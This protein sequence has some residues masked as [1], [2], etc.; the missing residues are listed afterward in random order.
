[1]AIVGPCGWGKTHLLEAIAEKQK[2]EG[3]GTVKVLDVHQ[4][5]TA[6]GRL[7]THRALFLDDVQ[8]VFGKPKLRQ[9]LRLLLERRVKSG[10]P[11]VLTFSGEKPTRQMKLLL[12][13]SRAWSFGTIG[14]PSQIERVVII[15][16]MAQE[17]GLMLSPELVEIV[18]KHMRVN[19]RTLSGALKRLRLGGEDWTDHRG[20]LEALGVLNPFFSDNPEWDL[21]H[22]IFRAS[23][24]MKLPPEYAL[25]AMMCIANLPETNVARWAD[26]EPA[27]AFVMT[28]HFRRKIS[29]NSA[30]NVL[31][32]NLVERVVF[33]LA[34]EKPR[35]A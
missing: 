27:E 8:E 32:S 19:G 14:E 12:P 1:V 29:G 3:R 7:E 9:M 28:K 20:A 25:Y 16:Q 4:A 34:A 22:R 6:P 15:R 35:G 30:A 13:N 5:L 17:E 18:A 26:V 2:S 24:E 10:R 11:T 33:S 31:V 23:T 21:Q